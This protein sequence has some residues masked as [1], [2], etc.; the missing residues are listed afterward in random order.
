MLEEV[1]LAQGISTSRQ[2][3]ESNYS[4]SS[5]QDTEYFFVK[6]WQLGDVNYNDQYYPYFNIPSRIV[7]QTFV[8]AGGEE[9]VQLTRENRL[10]MG[11]Y[12]WIGHPAVTNLQGIPGQGNPNPY[13]DFAFHI[14]V[15]AE[16]GTIYDPSY[17]ATYSSYRDYEEAAIQAFFKEEV[18]VIDER[19]LNL[20]LNGNGTIE[21]DAT[22]IYLKIRPNSSQNADI[23]EF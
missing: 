6:N 12:N 10:P 20:D 13:S 17:G 18:V 1:F 5:M 23:K 19:D 7:E 15:K 21:S 22:F 11:H 4:G 8:G 14:V 2:W 16:N 3:V 9:I